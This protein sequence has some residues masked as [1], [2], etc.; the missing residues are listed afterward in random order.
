MVKKLLLIIGF[1]AFLSSCGKKAVYQLEGKLSNLD[2]QTIYAVFEGEG[3]RDVDTISCE[4]QGQFVIKKDTKGFHSVTLFFE[5]KTSWVT[6]YLEEGEVVR[7]SGDIAYPSLI[8]IKGGKINNHLDNFKKKVAPLLKEQ[9][10]LIKNLNKKEDKTATEETDLSSRLSNIHH[11]LSEEAEVYIKKHPNEEASAI[12][13]QMFFINS[14]DTR[15]LDELLAVLAP[16]LKNTP[17]VKELEQYSAK[18]KR[19]AIGVEAPGF[20]LKDV[21]GKSV[22][23]DSFPN[24]Y[25][26]LTFIAP[27]CDMCHTEDLLLDKIAE[28]YPKEKVD[29]L[30]ISLDDDPKELRDVLKDEKIHWNLVTDSASQATQMFELYNISSLPRCFLIDEEGK[31]ILKTDN[32]VEIKQTLDMLLD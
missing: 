15:Q 4:K 20:N 13:I 31:I 22:S 23:L 6:A 2:E 16:S 3:L 14:D 5:N 24:K 11:Q 7:V 1:V 8:Q 10:E 17:L 30:L 9:A 28:Q 27:W 26:L 29:M 12:L 32:G 19:T 18:V 21:Y 25:L